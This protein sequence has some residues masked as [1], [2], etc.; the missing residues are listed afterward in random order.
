MEP[1]AVHISF[2]VPLGRYAIETKQFD[3]DDRTSVL[4]HRLVH[5]A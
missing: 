4:V 5:G 3:P 2:D 1:G